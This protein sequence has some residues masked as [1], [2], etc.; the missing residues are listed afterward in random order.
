[1]IEVLCA[2]C[3]NPIPTKR[4]RLIPF[5]KYCADCQ[6]ALGDTFKYK[7]KTVGFSDEPT[8][9]KTAKDWDVLKKQRRVKDI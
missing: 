2:E 6:E 1:M 4:L 3:D 9:A 5:V 7:M 8:M